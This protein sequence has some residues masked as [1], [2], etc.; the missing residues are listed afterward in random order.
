MISQTP[1]YNLKVVLMETGLKADVIRAWER[2]YD[3]P[4]PQRTPAG[5]RLYSDYDL[6]TIQWLQKRRAEGLSIS[7]AV[8]LWKDLLAAGQ[9][10]LEDSGREQISPS[11]SLTGG[12]RMEALRHRWLAGCLAFD[13]LQAEQAIDQAFALYPIEQA[14]SAILQLGLNTIGEGW[15][16]DQVSVQQEHFASSLAIRRLQT[17][18]SAAPQPT[19][20]QTVLVDCAPG[21]RHTFPA[22]MLNL[23][24][25]RKGLNVVYLGADTP[26]EQMDTAIAAIHPDLVVLCAQQLVTAASLSAT[27]EALRTRGLPLAYGGLIFNRVP[28]LRQRMAASFLGEGL[29]GAADRVAE[30]IR[31]PAAA[32]PARAAQ[33]Y[34]ALARR[35]PRS[36]PLIED[37]LSA[38]LQKSGVQIKTIDQV[39]TLF[40]ERLAAALALDDLAPMQ[41]ELDWIEG[42]L[43]S[44]HVPIDQLFAYLAAY[45]QG[46]RR[47]LGEDGIPLARWIDE[48]LS[49]KGPASS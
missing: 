31:K 10:P 1:L 42:L 14:C 23:F 4:H 39:N 47:V 17:L 8:Q 12:E 9:D 43:T 40:G 33:E 19:L 48:Y 2:R 7:R 24:L 41:S 46:V 21:E 5:H 11:F 25:R 49:R 16:L 18:I 22:L 44:H 13:A 15:Y 29:E 6:A 36:R 3:L 28:K 30:L 20:R 35:Y 32:P 26:L 45:A 38:S 34:Q 27:A 37:E